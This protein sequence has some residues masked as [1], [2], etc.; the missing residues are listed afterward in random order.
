MP[1]R[2]VVPTPVKLTEQLSRRVGVMSLIAV[3]ALS[4]GLISD[5]LTKLLATQAN[6]SN[7]GRSFVAQFDELLARTS[8]DLA[9]T[10]EMIVQSTS[11]E[12]ALRTALERNPPLI[13]LK[14]VNLQ[15]V[16]TAD[17]RRMG[18]GETLIKIPQPWI[19][20][21]RKREQWIS[22]VY[23]HFDTPT[24]DIVL[25]VI[26]EEG[27]LYAALVAQIDLTAMWNGVVT[28]ADLDERVGY[29]VDS[30]GRLLVYR[31]LSIVQDE[32]NITERVGMSPAQLS[33]PS[34]PNLT[35]GLEGGL[36]VAFAARF[37]SV[38]WYVVVEQPVLVAFRTFGF[39]SLLYLVGFLVTGIM[40][41]RGRRFV[42]TALVKP[43]NQLREGVEEMRQGNL[44]ARIEI[45][46]VE[47]NE[48][49]T[50]AS[51]LNAMAERIETRTQE[52]VRANTA[53]RESARLKSE[54]ISTMSHELRTPLNAMLGFSGILMEGMGGQIDGEARH[55]ISRIDANGKRLLALINDILDV[56]KIEAGR[57]EIAEVPTSLPLLVDS[58]VVQNE[59][60]AH[61]K[62][63]DFRLELDPKLP[64]NILIDK[65]RLTQIAINLL[66]NA[67][68]FTEEGQVVLCVNHLG[69]D[70]FMIQVKDTGI[71]I[72]PHALNFIFD[73]FRQLDGS[74]RRVYGGT[75]LGLSIVRNLTRMMGGTI[76]VSST[77]GVG[78][79]F[80]V[81]LPLKPLSQNALTPN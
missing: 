5:S 60:L 35:I 45:V 20:S 70:Q 65:E 10:T 71:G 58:W 29:V 30:E 75:G 48:I 22:R 25:P 18:K 43:L 55:M 77:L 2:F 7:L 56:A 32:T 46:G 41:L 74:T 15:G 76:S 73:E 23:T 36:V 64:Q 1:E 12:Y 67:F 3:L 21:T 11:V 6:I 28:I 54:F 69:E 81:T 72:P 47:N 57:M 44:S 17:R 59:I 27:G 19:D 79:V 52:L 9:A 38:P 39:S 49:G 24:V 16:V 26:N 37:K 62:K 50:L 8:G 13:S 78:S 61:K 51:T 33:S 68:K 42:N 40:L 63:L 53:A 66:S 80:T 31:D 34:L 14:I 4:L